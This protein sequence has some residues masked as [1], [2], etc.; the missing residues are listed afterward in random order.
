ML[1]GQMTSAGSPGGPMPMAGGGLQ[2]LQGLLGQ[3]LP[4]GQQNLAQ[5]NF[6]Q[7]PFYFVRII[8]RWR[9]VRCLR[10]HHLRS[11]MYFAAFEDVS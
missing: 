10:V 8:L 11:F 3:P 4:P 9:L 7:V 6:F 2:G 1:P 5:S